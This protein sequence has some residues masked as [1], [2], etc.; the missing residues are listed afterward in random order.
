MWTNLIMG[1]CVNPDLYSNPNYGILVFM[2]TLR[3]GW[4]L[5]TDLLNNLTN[6]AAFIRSREYRI[7]QFISRQERLFGRK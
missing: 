2:L 6:Y 7:S 3:I 4:Y 1:Y 5:M